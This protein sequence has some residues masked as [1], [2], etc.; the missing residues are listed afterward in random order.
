[1]PIDSV[2]VVYLQDGT[3]ATVPAGETRS[4]QMVFG[5]FC[6]VVSDAVSFDEDEHMSSEEKAIKFAENMIA[7]WASMV[8]KIHAEAAGAPT[9]TPV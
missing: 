1:M 8:D 2:A 6:T 7:F 9:A 4:L 3:E 5:G